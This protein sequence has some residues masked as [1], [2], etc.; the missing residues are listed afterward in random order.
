MID[1]SILHRGKPVPIPAEV[2]SL[3]K[4]G[5]QLFATDSGQVLHVPADA[6]REVAGCVQ[7]ARKALQGIRV[8]P[9]QAITGFFGRAAEILS[10][11]NLRSRLKRINEQDVQ[12]AEALGRS[13]TRLKLDDRMLDAMQESFEIWA[14][15]PVQREVLVEEIRHGSWTVSQVLAPLGVVGFV[16]E[17]RPNVVVDACGVLVSGNSCVFRIGR[18]A[19]GTAE[20]IIREV[21]EPALLE[22]DLP[23][24]S[25][26]LIPRDDHASGWALFANVDISLAVAR[27]SGS[28]VRD[29]GSVASQSGVPVSLHGRGGAWFLVGDSADQGRLQ[30]TLRNS[31]DRKVCNTANVVTIPVSQAAERLTTV[32]KA[33]DEAAAARGSTGIVHLISTDGCDALGFVDYASTRL[34]VVV[35]SIEDLQKE[36]EW[37]DDPEISVLIVDSFDDAVSTFNESSPRLVASII[38][39]DPRDHEFGWNHLSC[40]FVGDGFSRWVDGQFALQRPELGLSNWESGAPLGR[41]AILSGGDIHSVRYRVRQ[42]D[43][44]LHR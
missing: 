3:F 26:V 22:S 18:D 17:G 1:G 23:A 44:N 7:R 42:H 25:V 12:R 13:T 21:V 5:D 39:E 30:A 20:A 19:R 24:D 11:Q 8:A 36:W 37:E 38:S 28:A 27:G 6:I 4:E 29:L 33:V 16:F 9:E 14:S 35:S 34:K 41:G 31:L 32:L 43:E 2:R 15:Q 40:P 10:N